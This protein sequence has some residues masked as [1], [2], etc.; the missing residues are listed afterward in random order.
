LSLY[1]LREE[2]KWQPFFY[3]MRVPYGIRF[4]VV[5]RLRSLSSETKWLRKWT[6]QISIFSTNTPTRANKFKIPRVHTRLYW[7]CGSL[8]A[9]VFG[10][11]RHTFN[12]EAI[13]PYNIFQ[14]RWP[15]DMRHQ[16]SLHL[17]LP[18]DTPDTIILYSLLYSLNTHSTRAVIV[19]YRLYGLLYLF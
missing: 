16:W 1:I 6:S 5:H 8:Y 13:I 12:R 9:A 3:P 7:W 2:S 18:A 19:S 4:S 15:N 14:P 10:F 17:I 11:Y